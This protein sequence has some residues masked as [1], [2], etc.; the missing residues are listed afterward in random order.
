MIPSRLRFG[1]GRDNT[2]GPWDVRGGQS[3]QRQELMLGP[4]WKDK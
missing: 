4:H 1:K 2:E 3:G